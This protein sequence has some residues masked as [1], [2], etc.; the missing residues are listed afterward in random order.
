M[1]RIPTAT[2]SNARTYN[3]NLRKR[4]AK[5]KRTP[6]RPK[7]NVGGVYFALFN[8]YQKPGQSSNRNFRLFKADGSMS[9]DIGF[10]RLQDVSAASSLSSLKRTMEASLLCCN[11]IMD[12]LRPIIKPPV[13]PPKPGRTVMQF[14]S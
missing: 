1:G 3:Y 8:E 4:L 14:L 9:Y 12:M 5:R 6:L 13:A 10:Y 7:K 11:A 2:P